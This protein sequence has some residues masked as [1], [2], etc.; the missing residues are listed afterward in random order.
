MEQPAPPPL[1]ATESLFLAIYTVLFWIV[2]IVWI[3]RRRRQGKW[4]PVPIVAA[5]CWYKIEP[6]L[7]WMAYLWNRKRIDAFLKTADDI[8]V[9]KKGVEDGLP[10]LPGR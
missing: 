2:V 3:V 10:R 4:V 8:R 6:A 1:G 7:A 5:Y 9:R